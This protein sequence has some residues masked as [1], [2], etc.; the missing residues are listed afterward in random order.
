[1][2]VLAAAAALAVSFF[3]PFA[4]PSGGYL[5]DVAFSPDGRTMFLTQIDGAEHT[6]MESTRLAGG[7]SKPRPL[8]F[9]GHWRDLEETL[10]PDGR[11]MIFASNR[12]AD[13]GPTPIDAHFGGKLRRGRGGDLWETSMTSAGWSAPTRLPDR[14]NANT[15]TFSPALAADGTLYFMRASGPKMTFHIF[16]AKSE[17][18][19]YSN[20]TLAPFSDAAY[21]DF[22]PTVAPD[23]SFVIFT[24]TRPPSAKGAADLFVSFHRDGRWTTPLDI[25]KPIDPAGDAIEPRLSPDAKVLYFTAGSTPRLEKVGIGA[26]V[27]SLVR[28]AGLQQSGRSNCTSSTSR[29]HTRCVRRPPLLDHPSFS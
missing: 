3:N 15:S 13:G 2:N 16:V 23:D 8:S 10:S 12:P 11:T 26:I 4:V 21:S 28:R 18:D 19:T 1:M 25:G 6:L 7:W 9:S 5:Q 17:R 27:G 24:S 22:D 29:P 20:S 14:V